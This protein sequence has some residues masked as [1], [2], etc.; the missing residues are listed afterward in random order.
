MKTFFA[1]GRM[2]GVDRDAM[3]ITAREGAGLLVEDGRIVAIG[4][5]SELGPQAQLVRDLGSASTIVPGLIDTHVHLALDGGPDPRGTLLSMGERQQLVVMLKNARKLLSAGVTTARDLGSPALLDQ[6]VKQAIVDGD[7]RG[8]R[9][10]TVTAPLTTTGGH[11]WFFGGECD[12][13]D[14]V[15]RRVRQA[16][17]EGADAIK[18]M[19]S[20]GHLTPGTAPARPQFSQ[21]E[22]EVIVEEAHLLG[23][24]V[25]AHAH[26]EAG[27]E[28]AIRAGVDSIEHFSFIE[29]DG[30]RRPN[31]ELVDL[32]ARA[33]TFVCPTVSLAWAHAIEQG[34][35]APSQSMRRLRDAG[36]RIVAGTDAGVEDAF[37]EEYVSGLEGMAALG[38]SNEE[39]LLAATATAAESLGLLDE[40]GTLEVGTSADFVVAHGDPRED[41]SSLRNP[42]LVVAAGQPYV[43]EFASTRPWSAVC[44][45]LS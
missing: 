20:G 25:T 28:R 8:P 9:L 23:L 40:T 32:A 37:H 15:R 7:A 13:V 45:A 22:L 29:T 21:Q 14:D 6:A 33:G 27:I 18:V 44:A 3:R 30:V 41:L 11:C 24:R 38:M 42:A 43:P 35:F 10:V 39:V 5:Q 19:A 34:H 26:A 36:I 4:P 1:A 12:G 31:A 16:R 17:R 2:L